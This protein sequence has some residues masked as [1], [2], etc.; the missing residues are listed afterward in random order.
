MSLIV[1]GVCAPGYTGSECTECAADT[2]KD[3]AGS[4]ACSSC[5]SG[6]S[7]NGNTGSTAVTACG[8]C[9]PLIYGQEGI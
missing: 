1:S 9:F 6:S 4:Q 8:L 3:T 5:P 7:T 2:Y